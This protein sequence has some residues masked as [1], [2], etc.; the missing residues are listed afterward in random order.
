MARVSRGA[1][2][3]ALASC[4]CILYVFTRLSF[5]ALNLITLR[6]L[7]ALKA[8]KTLK[9][10]LTLVSRIRQQRRFSAR[11]ERLCSELDA[12]Q[13]SF[14]V[15]QAAAACCVYKYSWFSYFRCD[16]ATC[17]RLVRLDYRCNRKQRPR[18]ARLQSAAVYCH[19]LYTRS[20]WISWRLFDSPCSELS[21]PSHARP[22]HG[23]YS[24]FAGALLRSRRTG[25]TNIESNL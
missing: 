18:L 5:A 3:G 15:S 4:A 9:N 20:G 7:K 1:G 22:D 23:A 21:Y 2:G 11:S 14:S 12:L 6:A 16:D 10:G 17:G 25:T 19:R 24:R 8:L 13:A